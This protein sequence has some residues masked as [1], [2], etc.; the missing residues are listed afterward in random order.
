MLQN[1]LENLQNMFDDEKAALL[2]QLKGQKDRAVSERERQL[3]IAKLRRDKKRLEKED[4]LDSA[5]LI[6]S[7]A[8]EADNKQ[9]EK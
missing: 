7:M 6:L 5:A 9:K 2:A 4:K 1:I 3:A 8:K